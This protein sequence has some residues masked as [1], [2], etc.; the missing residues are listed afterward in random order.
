MSETAHD[1]RSPLTT[2]RESM[3]LIKDGGNASLTSEE[4]L[5]LDAAMDQ[6]DCMFQ[7]INEMVQLLRLRTGIP[8]VDRQW[9]S[10]SKIRQSIE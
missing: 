6:C 2:V 8:R 9:V 1:L 10:I 3:R 7:M 5:Y 4:I